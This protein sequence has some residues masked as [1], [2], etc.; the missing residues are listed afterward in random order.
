MHK[1]K[2]IAYV[3]EVQTRPEAMKREKAIKRLTHQQ[4]ADLIKSIK[5]KVS[6]DKQ[7]QS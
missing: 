6:S 5:T 7:G 1:P 3:E 4:K 2:K